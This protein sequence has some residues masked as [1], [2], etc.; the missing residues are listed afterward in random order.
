MERGDN[1]RVLEREQMV[2]LM[3][4]F[5]ELFF[6]SHWDPEIGGRRLENRLQKGDQV[7]E[8]HLRAWRIARE[9]ILGNVLRW[10]RLVIEN[11]NAFT[12]RPPVDRDRLIHVALP[13]ELW[14]RIEAFLENLA[15]L[16]CWVDKNLS[17]TVFGGKQIN[18]NAFNHSTSTFRSA[19][20]MATVSRAEIL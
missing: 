12:G 1:P 18:F 16:P 9:E 17:N 5:A 13:E 15:R 2:R 11:Y 3:S 10:V 14:R 7:P 19:R 20:P 4:S 8:M 6:V